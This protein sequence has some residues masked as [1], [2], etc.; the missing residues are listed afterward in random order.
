MVAKWS[1]DIFGQ[2]LYVSQMD[3]KSIPYLPSTP[4]Y[5]VSN[6]SVVDVMSTDVIYLRCIE[7]IDIIIKVSFRSFHSDALLT[8]H[9][10]YLRATPTTAS[11]L[12]QMHGIEM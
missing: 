7:K 4:P 10:R 3:D 11:L 6:L 12:W 2:S 9:H 5:G 8:F 1:G